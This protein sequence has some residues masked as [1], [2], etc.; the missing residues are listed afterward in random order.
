MISSN[1]LFLQ[2]KCCAV[3]LRTLVPPAP[4]SARGSQARAGG[5]RLPTPRP[6]VLSPSDAQTFVRLPT[7]TLSV[8][9]PTLTLSSRGEDRDGAGCRGHVCTSV[10]AAKPKPSKLPMNERKRC[11]SPFPQH[12]A[13]LGGWH[14][15][16]RD[17]VFTG[18]HPSRPPQCAVVRLLQPNRERQL[19]APPAHPS[20]SWKELF[21]GTS[22]SQGPPWLAAPLTGAQTWW[23]QG[24]PYANMAR[25]K[26]AVLCCYFFQR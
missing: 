21:P 19:V 14:R 18:K 23:Q 5:S 26:K 8:R 20:E 13:K 12:L 7:L 22:Q 16:E 6:S 10:G 1:E 9:L 25:K 24:K 15:R 2:S 11:L 4:H 17:C 3:E